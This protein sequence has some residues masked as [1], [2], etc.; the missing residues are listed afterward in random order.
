MAP[1][2]AETF[3]FYVYNDANAPENHFIPSGWMGDWGDLT[4]KAD[5]ADNCHGGATCLQIIYTGLQAQGAKWAGVYWQ[6]PP[7]NWGSKPGGFDLRGA[8]KLTFWARGE[9]GGEVID[10]FR[11]G[12]IPGEY[13]DSD[14]AYS[15]AVTLTTE[16]Q[17]YEISLEGRDLESIKGGFMWAAKLQDNKNGV[18]FYLDEIRYE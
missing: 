16:W 2:A 11:A 4:V 10:E 1:A 14:V 18:T 17:H 3:P 6:D 13:F 7:N 12:G 15:P 8:K 5:H 9:K